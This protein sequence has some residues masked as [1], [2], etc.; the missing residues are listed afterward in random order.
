MKNNCS[1]EIKNE[2]RQLKENLIDALFPFCYGL[3]GIA[4]ISGI[5]YLQ[6]EYPET[7]GVG[8]ALV[9]IFVG[10]V[11]AL[12]FSDAYVELKFVYWEICRIINLKRNKH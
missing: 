5:L 2:I 12:F 7:I 9:I 8:A 3:L 11:A 1:E 6:L 4:L 10:L